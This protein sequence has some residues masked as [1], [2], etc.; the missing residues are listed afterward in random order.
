MVYKS[1]IEKQ[2]VNPS[3]IVPTCCRKS[4]SAGAR[5]D[6]TGSGVIGAG[7]W[8]LQRMAAWA[9]P[10]RQAPRGPLHRR[11]APYAY[12]P[13]RRALTEERLQDCSWLVGSTRLLQGK[14]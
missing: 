5:C 12:G 7:R 2:Q 4:S 3:S 11:A 1:K 13:R 10:L 8:L 6:R 9:H 14:L